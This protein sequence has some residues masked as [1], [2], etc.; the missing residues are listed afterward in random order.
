MS[1]FVGCILQ[2]C[3]YYGP[4][5]S[6]KASFELSFISVQLLFIFE[7]SH[8]ALTLGGRYSGSWG[9]SLP[10]SAV[11]SMENVNCG[12]CVYIQFK[13]YHCVNFDSIASQTRRRT[14]SSC[15]PLAISGTSFTLSVKIMGD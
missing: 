9:L 4:V 5:P 2:I 14:V 6:G 11:F 13:D 8:G 15:K 7:I 3:V 12:V 1:L 10:S